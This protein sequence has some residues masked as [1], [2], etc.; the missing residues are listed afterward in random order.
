MKLGVKLFH[1]FVFFQ[2]DVSCLYSIDFMKI[3]K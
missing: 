3:D 1:S 2:Y